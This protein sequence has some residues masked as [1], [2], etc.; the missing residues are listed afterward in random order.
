LSAV[1]ADG[2]AAA[3]VKLRQ[4]VGTLLQSARQFPEIKASPHF[5]TLEQ[6]LID[7]ENRLTASRRFY[8]LAIEEYNTSLN[9]WP[10]SV[11]AAKRRMSTRQPYDL[12]IERVLIDEAVAIKF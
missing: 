4:S 6:Q 9:Q 7:A 10:G 1:S 12:G 3:D 11:I 8:N 5:Q 2:K